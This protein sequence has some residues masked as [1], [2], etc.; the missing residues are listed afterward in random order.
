MTTKLVDDYVNFIMDS[1]SQQIKEEMLYEYLVNDY[2]E[3]SEKEL[4]QQI[5][6][7]YGDEWFEY[8]KEN[9]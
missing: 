1:M 5:L 8:V 2:K 9:K 7:N 4:T 6:E 3:L